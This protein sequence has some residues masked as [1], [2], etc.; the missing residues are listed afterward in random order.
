[1]Q[2]NEGQ[3]RGGDGLNWRRKSHW[4]GGKRQFKTTNN[5]QSVKWPKKKGGTLEGETL[6]KTIGNKR[7]HKIIGILE[8]GGFTESAYVST[9]RLGKR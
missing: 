5:H 4:K 2:A 1:V 7:T 9:R 3:T 8:K 6:D